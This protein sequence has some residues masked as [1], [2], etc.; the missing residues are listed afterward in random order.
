MPASLYVERDASYL[1]V[2]RRLLGTMTRA[3][4]DSPAQRQAA[5][6]RW[7]DLAKRAIR[8]EDEEFVTECPVVLYRH[9]I[10]GTVLYADI[11]EQP[12]HPPKLITPTGQPLPR[13]PA[14]AGLVR[15]NTSYASW[16]EG[17]LPHIEP[18]LVAA[19]TPF[20]DPTVQAIR[21]QNRAL[22]DLID[23]ALGPAN[24]AA[25]PRLTPTTEHQVDFCIRG[26]FRRR[27][28]RV[29][30]SLQDEA[31]GSKILTTEGVIE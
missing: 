10:G 28:F 30:R 13:Q 19:P 16:A 29:L 31:L 25:M 18:D 9:P 4:W 5:L 3:E 1:L 26:V 12:G 24:F 22:R 14:G 8:V 15:H 20:D 2:R 6:D 7:W 27:D 11:R 23:G 21:S 17:P